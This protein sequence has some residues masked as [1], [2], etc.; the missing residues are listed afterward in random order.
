MNWRKY[1]QG[2]KGGMQRLCQGPSKTAHRR[3]KGRGSQGHRCLDLL[4]LV[5]HGR[6]VEI[7]ADPS[8]GFRGCVYPSRVLRPLCKSEGSSQNPEPGLF[9]VKFSLSNPSLLTPLCIWGHLCS[10]I[11]SLIGCKGL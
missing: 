10:L 11:I 7:K 2:G 8:P 3:G 9:H 5:G 4:M 6:Q 1:E